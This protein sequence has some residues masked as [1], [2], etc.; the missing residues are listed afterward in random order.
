MDP[1]ETEDIKKRWQ[2]YIEL[3]PNLAI[4]LLGVYPKE[5][6]ASLKTFVH[7]CSEHNIQKVKPIQVSI[8]R[9]TSKQN[10]V[11]TLQDPQMMHK[12]VNSTKIPTLVFFTYQM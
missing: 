9:Q 7:P 6:K 10:V 8:H 5:L 4:S 12:T 1:R 3:T 11:H 2:E